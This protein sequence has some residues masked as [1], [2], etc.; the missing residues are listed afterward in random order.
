MLHVSTQIHKWLPPYDSCAKLA[1]EVS[2]KELSKPNYIW[3]GQRYSQY[4]PLWEK[5]FCSSLRTPSNSQ[6]GCTIQV[7]N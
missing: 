7:N 3:Y 6:V 5:D 2:E 1:E 4:T